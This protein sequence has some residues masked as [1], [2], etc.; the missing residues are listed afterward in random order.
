ML[1]KKWVSQHKTRVKSPIS[2]CTASLQSTAKEWKDW[3]LPFCDRAS[4]LTRLI[5]SLFVHFDMWATEK[6]PF[7]MFR[8][9]V[10]S[11][12]TFR[13][14]ITKG[15]INLLCQI[16]WYVPYCTLVIC[17][18]TP[19]WLAQRCWELIY[20]LRTGSLAAAPQTGCSYSQYN[21]L[22]G[23]QHLNLNVFPQAETLV[24]YSLNFQ[25]TE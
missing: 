5:A 19:L 25:I 24:S 8:I 18:Q 4:C 6:Q 9:Q 1:F 7:M 14:K 13:G 12:L 3:F 23:K 2:L 21:T 11:S 17:Q 22:T 20:Y 10:F 15:S 16:Q